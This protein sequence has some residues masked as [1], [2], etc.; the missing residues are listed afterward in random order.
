MQSNQKLSALREELNAILLYL[1]E[2]R[3]KKVEIWDEFVDVIEQIKKVASEIRPTDF[4][5]LKVPADQLSLRKL[6]E[7]T[8]ELQS[9]QKKVSTTHANLIHLDQCIFLT[10]LC[11]LLLLLMLYLAYEMRT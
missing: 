1:E 5:P 8:K 2:M 7:L 9:L 4:V 3:K 6:D 10:L 11:G